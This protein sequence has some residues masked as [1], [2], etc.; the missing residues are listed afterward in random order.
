[1]NKDAPCDTALAGVPQRPRGIV[2]YIKSPPVQFFT[3][4]TVEFWPLVY[5][6]EREQRPKIIVQGFARRIFSTMS[7]S[8]L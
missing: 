1:M 7:P 8:L 5:Y 2:F 6:F 4:W 3:M